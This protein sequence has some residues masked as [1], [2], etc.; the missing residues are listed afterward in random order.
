[1]T[2]ITE[3]ENKLCG[4]EYQ[5]FSKCVLHRAKLITKCFTEFILDKKEIN[6]L[7]EIQL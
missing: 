7:K 2:R 1:M 6:K 5:H 4:F 3:S